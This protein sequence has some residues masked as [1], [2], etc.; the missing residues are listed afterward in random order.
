MKNHSDLETKIKQA[1]EHLQVL[2][3]AGNVTDSARLQAR[4]NCVGLTW[5]WTWLATKARQGTVPPTNAK[6]MTTTLFLSTIILKPLFTKNQV[7]NKITSLV[8]HN[9][10]NRAVC[11]I[12][13]CN[14][15]LFR[16]SARRP[17]LSSATLGQVSV[18]TRSWMTH[19]YDTAGIRAHIRWRHRQA[20]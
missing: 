12:V 6:T 17:Y 15:P 19:S 1:R 5:G 8:F 13:H 18:C 4:E 16:H 2:E 9:I 7:K 3:S 20:Y 10:Y 11:E 14:C